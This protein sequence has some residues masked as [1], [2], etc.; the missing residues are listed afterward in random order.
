MA[1]ENEQE[2]MRELMNDI[3]KLNLE[4]RQDATKVD[5]RISKIQGRLNV[6]NA[7]NEE[8]MRHFIEDQHSSGNSPK[9]LMTTQAN[10]KRSQSVA[11]NS[12]P[13]TTKRGR[14]LQYSPESSSLV[15]SS[16]LIKERDTNKDLSIREQLEIDGLEEKDLYIR[17]EFYKLRG[18]DNGIEKTR[19]ELE[20]EA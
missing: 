11:L 1:V 6:L 20:L 15:N 17:Q 7:F 16:L 5:N 8:Q 4:S 3:V 9:S 13:D 14:Q 18:A 12:R 10:Q 2:D 19:V